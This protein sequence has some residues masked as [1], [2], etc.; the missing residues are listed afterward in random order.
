MVKCPNCGQE[1]KDTN[2]NCVI[3]GTNL[4]EPQNNQQHPQQNYQPQNNAN[5]QQPYQNPQ[6]NN[7]NNQQNYQNVPPNNYSNQQPPQKKKSNTTRN[8]ILGIIAVCCIGVIIVMVFGGMASDQ[9]SLSSDNNSSV[10]TY[11]D[12][13]YKVGTDLPPGEYKFTQTDSISGYIQRSSDSSMDLDSIIS[14]DLTSEE[15]ATRYVTTNEGEY[16]KVQGGTLVAANESANTTSTNGSY[17]DGTYKVGTDIPAGEYKF[18]QTSSI[19]GYV[20]R[21]SDS[22]MSPESIISNDLTSGEGETI[23]VTTKD[24]EYLKVQGGTLE[25][26]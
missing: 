25:K 12:G 11:P 10:K 6:Y 19:T 8:I 13:T 15:G 16:L 5:N 23:Y 24:G 18:T 17:T 4:K 26:A 7:Y 22:S 3:C 1:N 21:A 9:G 20:E 14:N 2:I